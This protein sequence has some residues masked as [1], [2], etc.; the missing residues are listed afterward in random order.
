MKLKRDKYRCRVDW[1]SESQAYIG[2]IKGYPDMQIV[3][4]TKQEAE[5]QFYDLVEQLESGYYD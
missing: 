2:Y 1:D 3:A 4:E 5:E